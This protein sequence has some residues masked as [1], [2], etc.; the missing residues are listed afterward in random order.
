ME[1]KSK[2]DYE[3]KVSTAQKYHEMARQIRGR[4]LNSVAVL[5]TELA[6]IITEYFCKEGPRRDLFFS[7]I[8]T[9]Q[10]LSI[11]VKKEIFFKIFKTHLKDYVKDYP[12]LNK[13]F[14]SVI[15]YRNS[16]AHATIDVSEEALIKDKVTGVGFVG[17]KNGKR[18]VQ[19]I[20]REDADFRQAEI[21]TLL[22]DIRD[23]RKLV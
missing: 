20:S 2:E 7:E 22:G 11:R 10:Q 23:I 5:D 8:A 14:D 4:Y 1:Y 13:R 19:F 21:N 17:Y 6:E 16:L 12:L 18:E 9:S 3:R 15:N